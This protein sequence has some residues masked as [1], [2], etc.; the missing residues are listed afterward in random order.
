MEEE[1]NCSREHS[2]IA[3]L[4]NYP[5]LS[6]IK[7]KLIISQFCKSEVLAD[8]FSL[9]AMGQNQD[10]DRAA[11]LVR[12]ARGEFIS[13]SFRLLAGFCFTGLLRMRSSFPCWL[14]AGGGFQLSQTF[15]SSWLP[16]SGFKASDSWVESL[17]CFASLTH[18]FGFIFPT[19][20]FWPQQGKVLHF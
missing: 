12:G 14:L 8:F 6:S 4:Q 3:S 20:L 7:Y 18:L 13:S 5:S 17:L 2:F 16:S 15:L 19:Y 9:V 1:F 11:F 10:G